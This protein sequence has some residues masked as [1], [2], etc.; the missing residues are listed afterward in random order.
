MILFDFL[1]TIQW[2]VQVDYR[3]KRCRK[4]QKGMNIQ[5]EHFGN[6]T[7]MK[8]MLSIT[9][10]CFAPDHSSMFISSVTDLG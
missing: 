5:K 8:M 2:R 7:R 4:C 10:V 1:A 9:A 6:A 3:C